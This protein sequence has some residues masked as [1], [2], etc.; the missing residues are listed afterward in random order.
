MDSRLPDGA[1]ATQPEG[2]RAVRQSAFHT[3]PHG[4]LRRAGW[5]A[6]ALPG[7]QQGPLLVRRAE[8]QR[9]IARPRAPGMTGTR[10]ALAGRTPALDDV[11]AVRIR[12]RRPPLA[13]APLRTR[14][15]LRLPV[16]DQPAASEATGLT[17]LPVRVGG[18][19]P[20]QIY[21]VVAPTGD[22]QLRVHLARIDDMLR[23]E[24]PFALQ[25]VVN[26]PDQSALRGGRG[27]G[28]HLRTEMRRLWLAGLGQMHLVA[29]P[30]RVPLRA[31][32][33]VRIVGG[34]ERLGSGRQLV[35][36]APAGDARADV[37]LLGPDLAQRLHSRH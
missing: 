4:V 35:A 30:G 14:R 26:R 22:Q 20:E 11:V 8:R 15:L 18:R 23:W 2:A 32:A 27:G 19:R 29:D 5:C 28:F 16:N 9:P 7:G 33:G 6:C 37:I 12:G 34:V 31:R 24:E 10:P 21:A 17:R 1:G 36:G 25:G 13:A 3:S